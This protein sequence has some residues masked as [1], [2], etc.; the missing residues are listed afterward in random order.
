V[1]GPEA[2]NPAKQNEAI[3]IE[4]KKDY[5]LIDTGLWQLPPQQPTAAA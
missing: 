1:V 5:A 4:K 3:G 2:Y